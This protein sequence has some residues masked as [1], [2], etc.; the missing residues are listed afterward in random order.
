MT[1]RDLLCRDCNEATS[2]DCG[3]HGPRIYPTPM[4]SFIPLTEKW[5]CKKCGSLLKLCPACRGSGIYLGYGGPD[6]LVVAETC[7]KCKGERHICSKEKC[8]DS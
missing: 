8:H 5:A 7:P 1:Y 6:N 3:K 4:I 2:G